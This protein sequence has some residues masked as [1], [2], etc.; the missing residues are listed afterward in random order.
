MS[1]T[2]ETDTNVF[3]KIFDWIKARVARDNELAH[4]SNADL[5]FLAADIGVSEADFRQ[6]APRISDHSDLMEDM[7]RARGLDPEVIRKRFSALVRDM[8]VTCALCPSP[9]TCRYGMENGT[10][11]Y[12]HD[13]CPNAEIMDTLPGARP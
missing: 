5:Q 4:L 2:P 9:L 10:A 6:I 12:F 3:I 11:Q 13:F 8:E 7:M 1:A